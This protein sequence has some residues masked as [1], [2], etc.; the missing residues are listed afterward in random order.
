[1]REFVNQRQSLADEVASALS[2]AMRDQKFNMRCEARTAAGNTQEWRFDIE[3]VGA[4]SE[5]QLLSVKR[6]LEQCEISCLVQGNHLQFSPEAG[7]KILAHFASREMPE[8][9]VIAMRE[10]VL[11][12]GSEMG[13][14][15]FVEKNKSDTDA[16][17]ILARCI[18]N[19]K[20][21]EELCGYLNRLKMQEHDLPFLQKLDEVSKSL[22]IPIFSEASDI[23]DLI[24]KLN[25]LPKNTVIPGSRFLIKIDDVVSTLQNI[26]GG[27]SNFN[28]LPRSFG[29]RDAVKDL[30]T[31]TPKQSL[32]L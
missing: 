20:N 30:M 2:A 26:K 13:D 18:A 25:Q 6:F 1:M 15:R 5:M 22:T 28:N 27:A 14:Q 11:I 17:E 29:I 3:F 9:S 8:Q 12:S 19:A 16:P 21:I 32:N 23:D 24:N 4:T 10:A 7:D 31:Q